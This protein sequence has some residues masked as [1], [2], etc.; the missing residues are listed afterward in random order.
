MKFNYEKNA[1]IWV[2]EKIWRCSEYNDSYRMLK[3]ATGYDD[4]DFIVFSYMNFWVVFPA[5]EKGRIGE[6]LQT[7][8][9]EERYI[10]FLPSLEDLGVVQM[11]KGVWR[12]KTLWMAGSGNEPGLF[13]ISFPPFSSPFP[14]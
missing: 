10:F 5:Y 13:V 7:L 1:D 2:V 12:E 9:K 6:K 4:V 3:K 8:S 14:S 11:K